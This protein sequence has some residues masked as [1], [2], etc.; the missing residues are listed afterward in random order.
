MGQVMSVEDKNVILSCA[1]LIIVGWCKSLEH[2]SLLLLTS[3]SVAI[4][5]IQLLIDQSNFELSNLNG[6]K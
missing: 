5:T 4:N 6:F 3:I 1:A 2:S